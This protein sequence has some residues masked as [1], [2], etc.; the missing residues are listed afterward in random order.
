VTVRD[1]P[2]GDGGGG[3]SIV[4][5]GIAATPSAPPPRSLG[6]GGTAGFLSSGAGSTNLGARLPV[7][8]A[9]HLPAS[10][11]ALSFLPPG[12]RSDRCPM[13]TFGALSAMTSPGAGPST[14]HARGSVSSDLR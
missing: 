5:V 11:P 10:A 9:H 8:D 2:G 7:A 14:R 1:Q 3:S 6:S 12:N 13:M 4:A